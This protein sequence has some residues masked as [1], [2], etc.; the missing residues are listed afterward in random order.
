MIIANLLPPTP[1]TAP[2]TSIAKCFLF[3]P[4]FSTPNAAKFCRTIPSA[5]SSSSSST[6]FVSGSSNWTPESWKSK[7]A[8]QLPEYPDPNELDSVLRVLESFP[9]IVFAGEARKLEES[10]AK[11]A[12]GEAFLL[13]GG[14]CAESFKEFNGNNIRDTFRV[15]LQMG[16]VL[17]Y[18]AQMPI[19]K[20]CFFSIV[21]F[22]Y[23]FLVNCLDDGML[24]LEF[25]RIIYDSLRTFLLSLS[26][27]I[28]KFF[29]FS[30]Q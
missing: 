15:L 5:V 25:Y 26:S 2:T 28:W 18:G 6:H 12:V 11:A 24:L 30:C 7:R 10:L 16:I 9:P 27:V 20:V 22:P 14:D 8:L 3:K 19:I 17:T 21:V 29:I 4:H 1:S 23:D 13:Q